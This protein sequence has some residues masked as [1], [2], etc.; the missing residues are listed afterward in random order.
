MFKQKWHWSMS[1]RPP[2]AA[3]DNMPVSDW[4]KNKYFPISFP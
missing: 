2:H 3:E 1:V 4:L